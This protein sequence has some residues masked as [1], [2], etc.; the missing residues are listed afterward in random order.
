VRTAEALYGRRHQSDAEG[1]PSLALVRTAQHGVDQLPYPLDVEALQRPVLANMLDEV[2]ERLAGYAGI[3]QG[4]ETAVE[5][6]KHLPVQRLDG[7]PHA[8][9]ANALREVI[10]PI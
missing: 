7:I 3:V 9:V 4:D 1:V 5:I 6:G 10:E 8:I 2:V